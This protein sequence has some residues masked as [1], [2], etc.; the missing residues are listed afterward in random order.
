LLAKAWSE[1][2]AN[3]AMRADQVHAN[4]AGYARFTELLVAQL[5]ASG[6]LSA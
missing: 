4:A 5:K 6:F 1:V 3:D 2:L